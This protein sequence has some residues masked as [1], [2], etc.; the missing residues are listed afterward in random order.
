MNMNIAGYV[1]VWVGVVGL[2]KSIGV[3]RF[4]DASIIL[5]VALIVVGLSLKHFKHSAIC[6]VGGKCGF[7][8]MSKGHKCEGENCGTCKVK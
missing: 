4:V 6:C 5:P 2:L 3:I 1:L 8:D 7:C